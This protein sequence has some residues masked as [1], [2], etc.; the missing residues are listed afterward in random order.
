MANVVSTPAGID[1]RYNGLTTSEQYYTFASIDT[2]T[3]TPV[4]LF[5]ASAIQSIVIFWLNINAQA[6]NGT[7]GLDD[8]TD[9]FIQMSLSARQGRFMNF[10]PSP[11]ILRPD[12]GVRCF[13]DVNTN[14]YDL[15]IGWGYI[16]RN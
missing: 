16:E 4:E 15:T 6:S 9:I 7:Y 12:L 5:D 10:H 14:S 11:I 13:A 8:G 3:G 1:A 2:N